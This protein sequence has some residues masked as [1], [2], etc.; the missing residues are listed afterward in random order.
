MARRLDAEAERQGAEIAVAAVAGKRTS[1]IHDMN[2]VGVRIR[3]RQVAAALD[4]GRRLH[5]E[6]QALAADLA[7][8]LQRLMGLRQAIVSLMTET[9]NRQ[10]P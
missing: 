5:S 8:K 9:A 4:E 6:A 1:L 10:P 3:E 7:G 2:R